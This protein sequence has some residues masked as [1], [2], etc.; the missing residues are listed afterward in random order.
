MDRPDRLLRLILP[1]TFAAVFAAIWVVR[2]SGHVALYDSIISAWG[3]IPFDFPFVDIHG[4][5]SSVECWRQGID[6]YVTNPCDVLGRVFF[7]SPLLLWL[8]PTGFGV[9]DTPYAGLLVDGLFMASLALLPLPR[10]APDFALVILALLSTTTVFAAERAN[11]D[12][13][14]F[15]LAASAAA[16]LVR[17]W[18]ARLV[19]YALVAA[20]ALIKFY[21]VALVLLALREDPRRFAAI[22][23]AASVLIMS[24]VAVYHAELALALANVPEGHYFTDL[25]GAVNLP[26]GLA[27]LD[28]GLAPA[29]LELVLILAAAAGAVALA[30]QPVVYGAWR[31]LPEC[32]ALFLATGA[33]LMTSCFF[34]GQSIGYRGVFLLLTLPGLLALARSAKGIAGRIFG[35]TAGL[36]VWLMWSELFRHALAT[37]S[38]GAEFA[39]WLGRE[40]A[41]WWVMAVLG[42]TLLCFARATPLGR[43]V[44]STVRP[45]RLA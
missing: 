39:F 30:F 3:V 7:Y 31:R 20:G 8:A 44:E 19:A 16:L 42:G 34:A 6:V 45:I 41:W 4:V 26:R 40:L 33:V 24:F 12:L 14:M 43:A 15:A 2:A 38:P 25:F 17:T 13:L 35:A 36:V 27:I 9:A 11:I 37:A 21:P 29:W 18:R 23:G 28:P 10:K 1:A 32:E 22:A 5:L